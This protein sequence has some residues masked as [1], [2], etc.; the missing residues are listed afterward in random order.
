MKNIEYIINKYHGE[1]REGLSKSKNVT[2]NWHIT[3]ISND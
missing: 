2:A 1:W 3:K